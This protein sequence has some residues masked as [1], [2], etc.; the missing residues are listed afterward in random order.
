MS[1]RFLI[2]A[3]GHMVVLFAETVSTQKAENECVCVSLYV[4][5]CMC[6]HVWWEEAEMGMLTILD[7][8]RFF[9]VFA[10]LSNG[11]VHKTHIWS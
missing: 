1:P 2:E 6:V 3:T 4:C 5:M 11:D 7:I 10:G 8:N 9:L